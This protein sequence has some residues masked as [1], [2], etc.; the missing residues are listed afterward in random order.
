[1]KTGVVISMKEYKRLKRSEGADAR[2]KLLE[3]TLTDRAIIINRAINYIES[4]E[5]TGRGSVQMNQL[6]ADALRIL[7]GESDG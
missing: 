6:R 4:N 1:M 2:V 5:P 3:R 7:R